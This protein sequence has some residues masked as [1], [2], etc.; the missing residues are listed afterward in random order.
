MRSLVADAL[1]FAGV[2]ELL[3]ALGVLVMRSPYDR[4]HY[5][6]AAGGARR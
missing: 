1:L 4:L 6:A 3:C 2:L 5:T